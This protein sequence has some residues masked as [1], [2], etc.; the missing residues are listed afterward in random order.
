MKRVILISILTVF[1]LNANSQVVVRKSIVKDSLVWCPLLAGIPTVRN[2]YTETTNDYT[3]FFNN[4]EYKVIVDR[5]YISLGE[6]E[7]ALKFFNALQS[8]F[9]T[10]DDM[11]IEVDKKTWIVSKLVFSIHLSTDGISFLLTPKQ[12]SAIIKKLS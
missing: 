8:V 2:Y 11:V 4:E 6:K 12:V 3:L 7:D 10:G 9:N 5:Q 1:A